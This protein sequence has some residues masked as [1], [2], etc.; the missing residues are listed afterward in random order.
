MVAPIWHGTQQESFDLSKAIAHN[1]LCAYS[2]MNGI[3]L[4]TCHSHQALEW[5]QKWLDRM[6]S[7]RRWATSHMPDAGQ[8]VVR[9]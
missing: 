9:P 6:I 4:T 8:R 3:R 5:D 7:I 1:C 2:P